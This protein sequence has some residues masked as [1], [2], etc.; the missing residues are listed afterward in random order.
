M[1][2]YELRR[3]SAKARDV[4]GDLR[5]SSSRLQDLENTRYNVDNCECPECPCCDPDTPWLWPIGGTVL[6]ASTAVLT[7]TTA[8]EIASGS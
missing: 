7:V 2:E 4:M 8:A 5:D 3:G 6:A 1:S